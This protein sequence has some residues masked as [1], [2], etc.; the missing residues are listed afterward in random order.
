MVEPSLIRIEADEVTYSL[1]IIVRF[2]IERELFQGSLD[3]AKLPEVWREKMKELLGVEP[4]TDAQ[5]VLQDV[6]WSMGSFGTFPVTPLGIFMDFSSGRS[7][8]QTYRTQ[9]YI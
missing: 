5:G 7:L 2:E 9:S 1:H 3:P 8:N 4:E 6:H